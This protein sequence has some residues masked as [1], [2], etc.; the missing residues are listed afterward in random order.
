MH[1]EICIKR[2]PADFV[3]R[4]VLPSALPLSP[5][6]LPTP[7]AP[8]C[9]PRWYFIFRPR[10]TPATRVLYSSYN[11]SPPSP[12]VIFPLYWLSDVWAILNVARNTRNDRFCLLRLQKE[13]IN[14]RGWGMNNGMDCRRFGGERKKEFILLLLLFSSHYYYYYIYI[15]LLFFVCLYFIIPIFILFIIYFI[16]SIFN[17]YFMYC[18]KGMAPVN[19]WNR[20]FIRW[21]FGRIIFCEIVSVYRD[22]EH[23][24]Q[25]SHSE[26]RDLDPS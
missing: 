5:T 21:Y 13:V 24:D 25:L 6:P 1:D 10:A 23:S 18:S 22:F 8:L 9:K 11:S 2:D 7:L 20:C 19:K 3:F 4:R 16:K 26:F 17:Q 12:F 14:R 15:Y